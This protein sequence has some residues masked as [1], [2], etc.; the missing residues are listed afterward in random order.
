MQVNTQHRERGSTE[1]YTTEWRGESPC[2]LQS[3]LCWLAAIRALVPSQGLWQAE[4]QSFQILPH[5]STMLSGWLEHRLSKV[6]S[7]YRPCKV[8]SLCVLAPIVGVYPGQPWLRVL[9]FW[10]VWLH[11]KGIPI[12]CQLTWLSWLTWN[13]FCKVPKVLISLCSVHIGWEWAS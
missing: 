10:A 9:W 8:G 3:K 7:L 2:C 13:P 4:A 12:M 11:P 6:F 5:L 1:S